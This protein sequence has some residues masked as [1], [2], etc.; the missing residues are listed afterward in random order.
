[1]RRVVIVIY[2]FLFR[3]FFRLF[4][5][6]R[7]VGKVPKLKPPYIVLANHVNFIDPLIV[8]LF[9]KDP[10]LYV[11]GTGV[12]RMRFLNRL[13]DWWG[14]IKKKKSQSDM[15]TVKHIIK[16]VQ[17]GRVIGI[18]PEGMRVWDG[19]TIPIYLSTS[20]MIKNLK[21]PVM[22]CLIRGGFL[23]KPRWARESLKGRI[24]LTYKEVLTRQEV[25]QLSVEEIQTK[26]QGQLNHNDIMFN[27][28]RRIPFIGKHRA[29]YLESMLYMC[30]NCHQV[31]TMQSHRDQLFCTRCGYRVKLNLYFDFV[32]ISNHPLHFHDLYEWNQWQI[33]ESALHPETYEGIID[34][35]VQL[36]KQSEHSEYELILM[37]EGTIQFHHGVLQ[38][39]SKTHEHEFRF[40]EFVGANMWGRNTLEFYYHDHFYR[41][42]YRNP[43]ISAY[44][45][46][47]LKNL[48]GSVTSHGTI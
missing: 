45:W 17:K 39:K 7:R 33:K 20:K 10:I 14:V 26:I 13:V 34:S 21:V 4:F 44:K 25:E 6:V 41:L 32:Q 29:E 8:Q 18:F 38:F 23:A 22:T 47:V 36:W 11:A 30:A 19:Q 24:E 46:E 42:V 28:V 37:G 40:D 48:K 31:N 16:S 15:G 2:Q 27:R 1:M 3:G 12:F 35:D 9:V 5:G 43:R